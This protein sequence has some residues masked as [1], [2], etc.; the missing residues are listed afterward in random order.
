MNFAVSLLIALLAT[1][2]APEPR[3]HGHCLSNGQHD[4]S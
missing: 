2:T 1:V 3:A 4:R